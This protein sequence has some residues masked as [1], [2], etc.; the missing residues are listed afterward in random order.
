MAKNH[1][2][3]IEDLK[4]QGLVETAPGV[5]ESV[6]KGI[7]PK[8]FDTL[9]PREVVKETPDFQCALK[10]EWFIKGNIPAKKN[11]RINF[12]KNG[13]QISIPSKKHKEYVVSTKLQY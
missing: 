11:S 1:R 8:S 5:F 7:K 10:T 2:Y 4:R 6:N 13:K 3:T 12:V 9:I